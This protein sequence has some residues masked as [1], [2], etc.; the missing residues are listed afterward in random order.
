MR[1]H[2][3]WVIEKEKK[4]ERVQNVSILN[5]PRR[6]QK[7]KFAIIEQHTP[8]LVIVSK[9]RAIVL[10]L[11]S[12][13]LVSF[14]CLNC[15]YSLS[16]SRLV[17]FSSRPATFKW[18]C[19]T[20]GGGK[21]TKIMSSMTWNESKKG[22]W[23]YWS[24]PLSVSGIASLQRLYFSLLLRLEDS[25]AVIFAETITAMVW[26]LSDANRCRNT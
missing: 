2:F 19:E 5:R 26:S 14:H 16:S 15:L 7:K 24:T 20:S 11:S 4:I 13:R 6:D 10:H 23:I 9:K 22:K 1:F 17:Q 25:I 21:S 12:S 8:G 3:D 18:T